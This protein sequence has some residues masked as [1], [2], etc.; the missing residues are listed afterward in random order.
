MDIIQGSLDDL[1][2]CLPLIRQSIPEKA[3]LTEQEVR[4]RLC[5]RNHGIV[6]LRDHEAIEGV[7]VWYEAKGDLYLWLGVMRH[8]GSGHARQLL[9]KVADD[10]NYRRWFVKT[11]VDNCTARRQLAKDGFREYQ[12]QDGLVYAERLD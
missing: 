12:I 3:G 5:S 9:N 11:S 4:D 8:P 10:T 2:A 7:M 6:L 1:I